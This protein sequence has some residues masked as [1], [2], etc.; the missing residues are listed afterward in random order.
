LIAFCYRRRR[1]SSAISRERFVNVLHDNKD[2]TGNVSPHNLPHY[3]IPEAFLVPDLTIGGTSASGVASTHDRPLSMSTADT[4]HPQTPVSMTAAT[5]TTRESG[6][7][8]QLR[9]LNIIRHDDAGPSEWP[10]RDGEPETVDLPPA[11]ANI[12]PAQHPPGTASTSKT[13]SIP[14]PT[15]TK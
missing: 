12:I 3:Y 6:P 4:P 11:Y 9:P 5:N 13:A 7:P 10:T 15:K 14:A 2:D 8:A 1:R